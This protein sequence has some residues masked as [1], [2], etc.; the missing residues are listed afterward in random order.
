M[1]ARIFAVTAVRPAHELARQVPPRRVRHDGRR[2]TTRQTARETAIKKNWNEQDRQNTGRIEEEV[3]TCVLV[4]K[5]DSF[6]PV[7]NAA[8]FYQRFVQI[9][10]FYDGNGRIGRLLVIAYLDSFGLFMNWEEMEQNGKWLKR[11]NDCHK[12]YNTL[13]YN[14][15]LQYHIS[16][17]RNYIIKKSDIFSE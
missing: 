13:K 8:E 1:Q 7:V 16:H 9:H 11:L 14:E 15:Y 6:D 2:T 12:R 4:L 5:R 3:N 17:W 10:P